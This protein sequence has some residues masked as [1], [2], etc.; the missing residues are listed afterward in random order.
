M[1]TIK[2]L[3]DYDIE[4]EHA[5]NLSITTTEK[6]L[7]IHTEHGGTMKLAIARGHLYILRDDVIFF[8]SNPDKNPLIFL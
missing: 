1:S 4:Q 7:E 5:G 3:I 2:I 8:T 6:M